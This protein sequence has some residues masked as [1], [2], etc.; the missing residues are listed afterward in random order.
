[1]LSILIKPVTNLDRKNIF[2]D[3][4][5]NGIQK[6]STLGLCDVVRNILQACALIVQVLQDHMTPIVQRRIRVSQ[7]QEQSVIHAESL[8]CLRMT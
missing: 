4:N 3:R 1:M 7:Q 6:L 8:T 2:I 5:T